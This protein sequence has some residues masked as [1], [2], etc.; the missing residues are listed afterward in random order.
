[1]DLSWLRRLFQILMKAYG[2]AFDEEW[3]QYFDFIIQ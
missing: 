2:R 1:M 3:L